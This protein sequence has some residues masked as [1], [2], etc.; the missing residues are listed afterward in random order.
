MPRTTTRRAAT[1]GLGVLAATTALALAAPSATADTTTT[2]ELA[3][4]AEELELSLLA[5]PDDEDLYEED[6]LPVPE[7]GGVSLALPD[8]VVEAGTGV[9]AVALSSEQ[10]DDF[11]GTT[12]PEEALAT[13][14]DLAVDLVDGSVTLT[15]PVADLRA[16]PAVSDEGGD[17]YVVVTGLQSSALPEEQVSTVLGLDLAPSLDADVLV[18]QGLLLASGYV[19]EPLELT[20]GVPVELVL[21]E[22][23]SFG[24]LGLNSL[25]ADS[26]VLFPLDEELYDE[27]PLDDASLAAMGT[28]R[29]Q[30]QGE[31]EESPDPAGVA[32]QLA[33]LAEDLDDV[34][35]VEVTENGRSATVTPSAELPAGEY[36]LEVVLLP[37]G[38]D[39]E[40]GEVPAVF[41]SVVA[42]ASL[43][44]APVEAA[45]APVPAPT[46]TATA[47]AAPAP[48]PVAQNPGLRSNTGVEGGG[49]DGGL[50]A[51]GAGLLALA[52]AGGTLAL[53][54]GR[55]GGA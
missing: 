43:A 6:L 41:G 22:N 54:T 5:L 51:A 15:L 34:V 9:Q 11:D 1:T 39:V 23:G 27:L 26:V 36:L 20:A 48:A 55:R 47:T 50:V 24:A 10:F 2:F 30:A 38:F 44:A 31:A 29:A 25:A 19:T 32:G 7:D 8:A 12:V 52:A 40:S 17:V 28:M 13:S 16:Q 35:T 37:E 49:V 53:R 4:S 42:D 14:E 45:P 33:D 3:P 21:P 18:L 46:A